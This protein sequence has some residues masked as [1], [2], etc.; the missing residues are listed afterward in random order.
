MAKKSNSDL[1]TIASVDVDTLETELLSVIE[2][3]AEYAGK[4][5]ST[6]RQWKNIFI[7]NGGEINPPPN[8]YYRFWL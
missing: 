8:I 7:F 2:N 6:N 1:V 5:L 4:K 3:N